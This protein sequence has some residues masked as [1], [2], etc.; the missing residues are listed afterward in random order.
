CLRSI[1]LDKTAA[2]AFIDWYKPWLQFHS[3]LGWLKNPPPSYQQPGVDLIAGLDA[4]SSQ[5]KDDKFG[6]EYEFELA[7]K[8]LLQQAHDGHLVLSLPILGVFF[9][10]SPYSFL[11]LS[12]DGIKVPEVYFSSRISWL[13][14]M[15]ADIKQSTNT[16]TKLPWTPSAVTLVNGQRPLDY[17]S[18]WGRNFT[19]GQID[20]NGEW[21]GVFINSA[22]A[23]GKYLD[24][25]RF[26]DTIP[27]NFNVSLSFANGTSVSS[28]WTGGSTKSL[29]GI[30]T[31]QD[32]YEQFIAPSDD[33]EE[34]EEEPEAPPPKQVTSWGTPY[35]TP[36]VA[37]QNLTTDGYFTGYFLNKSSIAVMSLPSFYFKT[38][39]SV[40]SFQTAVAEFL[41]KCKAAGMKKLVIDLQG[42]GGG[43]II[44]GFDL[45]KQIF[46]TLEPFGGSQYRA[47]KGVDILGS[48]FANAI[49]NK[50]T[51]EGLIQLGGIYNYNVN[52]DIDN[53]Q[54]TSW[55]ANFGPISQGGDL[56]SN[57]VRIDLKN[58]SLSGGVKA[59]FSV[60]GYG[61]RK[62]IPAAMFAPQ[63]VLLLTDGFCGSTCTIF[64]EEMHTQAGVKMVVV[65]GRPE[66]GPMQGVTGVRGSQV[67]S[68]MEFGVYIN[69]AISLNK[70]AN[71]KELPNTKITI[72]IHLKDSEAISLNSRNQIRKS[73]QDTPLQFV[74]QAAHC[75]IWYTAASISNYEVLWQNAADALWINTSLCVAGSTNHP[76]S[77]QNITTIT[78][79]PK[80]GNGTTTL[81]KPQAIS[82]AAKVLYPRLRATVLMSVTVVV[83]AAFL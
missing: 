29:I 65:G 63:D 47:T 20:P 3:T 80:N 55:L 68:G 36:V 48:T 22:R 16:T 17:F 52:L 13:I 45:F 59:P 37:Q 30:E 74:Y 46:P 28:K 60:S 53:K 66:T 75:R 31:P 62:N 5:V 18:A 11:S 50:T 41:I 64:A 57:L 79:V 82:G 67:A 9:F 19:I 42:N 35:P 76:S 40:K 7:I 4:I 34:E 24:S 71:F 23:N 21:N 81:N 39:E 25:Y 77:A 54:Y 58:G 61:D 70:T 33:E 56:V 49:G 14:C 83:M 69:T 44:S 32:F 78:A 1:P 2:V 72:P 6:G 51:Q 15:V 8:S 43:R 26:T 38:D 27:A 12:P 73:K 10:K